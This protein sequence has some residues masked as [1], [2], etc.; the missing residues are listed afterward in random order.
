[1]DRLWGISNYLRKENLFLSNNLVKNPKKLIEGNTGLKKISSIN[2]LILLRCFARRC[3]LKI[4]RLPAC[5][6]NCPSSAERNDGKRILATRQEMINTEGKDGDDVRNK[7]QKLFCR[8]AVLHTMRYFNDW[9]CSIACCSI[10]NQSNL[11]NSDK[12]FFN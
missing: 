5:I 3:K 2:S 7:N 12:L 1:M 9:K 4:I 6:K 11:S 8:G 10:V